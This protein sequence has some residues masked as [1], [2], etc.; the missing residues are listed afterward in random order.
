LYDIGAHVIDYLLR[1]LPWEKGFLE[2]FLKAALCFVKIFAIAVCTA[3]DVV[4]NSLFLL[5]GKLPIH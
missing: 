4:Q 2:V 3:V 5:F 1:N